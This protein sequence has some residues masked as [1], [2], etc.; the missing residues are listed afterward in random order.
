MDGRTATQTGFM[1]SW[2]HRS[3][4]SINVD[5]FVG[6]SDSSASDEH[7]SKSEWEVRPGNNWLA[8]KL[9]TFKPSSNTDIPWEIRK[10]PLIFLE[11]GNIMTGQWMEKPTWTADDCY[12]E[13]TEYGHNDDRNAEQ[14]KAD[15]DTV[16]HPIT[17]SCN[18][19]IT[20]WSAIEWN[21]FRYFMVCSQICDGVAF[22]VD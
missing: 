6:T 18:T 9:T 7:F 10:T 14:W 22:K 21:F 20:T 12:R 15:N 4:S 16:V 2:D 13:T 17:S 19:Q 8:R 11:V 1:R 3:R 5:C